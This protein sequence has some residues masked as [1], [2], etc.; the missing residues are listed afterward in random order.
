MN[1]TSFSE[2]Q[3]VNYT[4]QCL[5]RCNSMWEYPKAAY[6]SGYQKYSNAPV[7]GG[8]QLLALT[9]HSQTCL[10]YTTVICTVSLMESCFF[11]SSYS[12]LVIITNNNK[13]TIS[14]KIQQL[15]LQYVIH[16]LP[17]TTNLFT[18]NS[19]LPTPVTSSSTNSPLSSPTTPLFFLSCS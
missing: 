4:S 1:T 8:I 18:S 17:C 19:P 10:H 3:E 2:E 13:P 11:V 6:C 7:H 5:T 16:T 9:H 12:H 14:S 15:L